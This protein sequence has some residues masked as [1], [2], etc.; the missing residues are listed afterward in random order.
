[1]LEDAVLSCGNHPPADGRTPGVYGRAH[2]NV[3]RERGNPGACACGRPGAEWA[4]NDDT[5]PDGFTVGGYPYSFDPAA[6]AP[7]CIRCHRRAARRPRGTE[8]LF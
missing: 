5:P 7:V 2:R 3:R 8:A 1:M 6:Y 4:F